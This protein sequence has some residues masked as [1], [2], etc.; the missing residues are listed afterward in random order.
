[1]VKYGNEPLLLPPSSE[2]TLSLVDNFFGRLNLSLK[3]FIHKLAIGS[4]GLKASAALSHVSQGAS[5]SPIYFPAS[6]NRVKKSLS[7]R[8]GWRQFITISSSL[9]HPALTPRLL[10]PETIPIH[11]KIPAF[12]LLSTKAEILKF[13]WIRPVLKQTNRSL[14][15]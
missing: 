5:G 1:M 9:H 6:L 10:H 8:P 11:P 3:K 14:L 7:F 2:L 4:L 13:F 12:A 15:I